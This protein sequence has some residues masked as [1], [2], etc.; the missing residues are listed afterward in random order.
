MFALCESQTNNNHLRIRENWLSTRWNFPLRAS[1]NDHHSN[2]SNFN[3]A[4][5]L[6]GRLIKTQWI[7]DKLKERWE[8][9]LWLWA[10]SVPWASVGFSGFTLLVG[11]RP[12]CGSDRETGAKNSRGQ[13]RSE[14]QREGSSFKEEGR[15]VM[16]R[17]AAWPQWQRW[18]Q[19]DFGEKSNTDGVLQ[20][21]SEKC[22][23][24][25][26]RQ[27]VKTKMSRDPYENI[28]YFNVTFNVH[29]WSDINHIFCTQT[30]W[31]HQKLYWTQV[32]Y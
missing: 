21:L 2:E 16:T 6:R 25:E 9:A 10:R 30:F 27:G 32:G 28:L 19:V 17:H 4:H 8:V 5:H 31:T 14:A 20:L 15:H 1:P 22:C 26:V 29:M 24:Y 13:R 18:F 23:N 3:V 11:M 12:A 7:L